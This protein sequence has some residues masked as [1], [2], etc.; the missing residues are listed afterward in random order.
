M[1]KPVDSATTF[2]EK[3]RQLLKD[4]LDHGWTSTNVAAEMNLLG[5]KG[6]ND[7]VVNTFARGH[8]Q[9]VNLDEGLSLIAV[10]GSRAK[11]VTQTLDTLTTELLKAAEHRGSLRREG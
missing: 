3:V 8:R 1:P 11:W 4:E 7:N 10:F 9:T 6:W 5:H 2:I